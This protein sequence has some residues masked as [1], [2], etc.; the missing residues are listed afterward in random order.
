MAHNNNND[1]DD[2]NNNKIIIIIIIYE[3]FKT[4]S[5]QQSNAIV[6]GETRHNSPMKSRMNFIYS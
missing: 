2:D 3:R 5:R 6:R 4:E 1:D